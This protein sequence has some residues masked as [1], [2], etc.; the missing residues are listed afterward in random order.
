M[1]KTPILAASEESQD[2]FTDAIDQAIKA[3][4]DHDVDVVIPSFLV[5]DFLLIPVGVIVRPQMREFCISNL[6]AL[7][8]IDDLTRDRLRQMLTDSSEEE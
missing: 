6:A 8:G 3:A 2:V 5:M 7:P 1:F 4:V